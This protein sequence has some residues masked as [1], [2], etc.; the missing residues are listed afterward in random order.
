[1]DE[2]WNKIAGLELNAV[3]QKFA[4]KKG[5]WWRV[6]R[7]AGAVEREYRQ[8]LYLIVCNPGQTVVPWSRDLDDFWH[9][10]ILHTAKY[11]ADCQTIIGGMIHHNPHLPEGSAPHLK[12]SAETRKMYIAA[13]RQSALKGRKRTATDVGGGND[14]PVVFCDSPAT[15]LH[16]PGGHH[17][18]AGHHAGGHHSAGGHHDAGG[19]SGSHS[20][21]GGHGGGHGCGGHGGH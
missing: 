13:F 3:R 17:G 8:F 16:Q 7:D 12:A 19:H 14:A 6:R 18:I 10:H 9:E 11:A 21:C 2:R 15:V 4:F 5:F 1:M 20:S